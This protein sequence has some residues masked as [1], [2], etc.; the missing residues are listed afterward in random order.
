MHAA[1][2][3]PENRAVKELNETLGLNL[4]PGQIAGRTHMGTL[5]R[6]YQRLGEYNIL[7]QQQIREVRT[8]GLEN[9]ANAIDHMVDSLVASPSSPTQTG[10]AVRDAMNAGYKMFQEVSG[11]IYQQ[12]DQA[13]QGVMVDASPIKAEANRW[14]AK[15]ATQTGYM[16]RTGDVSAGARKILE[17]AA[18]LPDWVPFSVAHEWRKKLISASPEVG[19]LFAG[20]GKEA[21][22]KMVG[23]VTET[24]DNSAQAL[25]PSAAR[26]WSAARKFYKNGAEVFD[27]AVINRMLNTDRG[28]EMVVAELKPGMVD[29]ATKVRSA[30]LDYPVKFGS[31]TDQDAALMTWRQL[32]EQYIRTHL[33]RAPEEGQRAAGEQLAT[34]SEEGLRSLK[35]NLEKQGRGMLDT[36]FN[37]PNIGS[38]HATRMLS[39]GPVVLQNLRD[40]GEAFSRLDRIPTEMRSWQIRGMELASGI[41]YGMLTGKGVEQSLGY[42]VGVVGI[43]E[44]LPWLITKS[45]YNKRASGYI[46]DGFRGFFRAT[47]AAKTTGKITVNIANRGMYNPRFPAV[48]GSL[49][50]NLFRAYEEVEKD[51]EQIQKKLSKGKGEFANPYEVMPLAP[52]T[53]P[54]GG[55]GDLSNP[56]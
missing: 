44:I 32:Q 42:G 46:V 17:D 51:S 52:R 13:A 24:M 48:A 27:N 20:E 41:L 7:S 1:V 36:M 35:K 31:K 4:T 8:E 30:I 49:A 33:L 37:P 5:Y 19:K 28:A 23:I 50:A 9:A 10:Y 45:V 26:L 21:A 15:A 2:N 16:P 39:G 12:L 22:K 14:L 29:Y 34:I 43:S 18:G 53:G 25:N 38:P 54:V 40:I 6:M 47:P 55:K 3:E 11:S 56:Y